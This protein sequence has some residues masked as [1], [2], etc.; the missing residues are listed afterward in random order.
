VAVVAVLANQAASA[1]TVPSAPASKEKKCTCQANTSADFYTNPT[2][3]RSSCIKNKNY[4]P[5]GIPVP[6]ICSFPTVTQALVAATVSLVSFTN[7]RAIL[8]GGTEAAPAFF[9]SESFPLSVVGGITLTTTD[10]PSLGGEGFH[11]DAYIILFNGATDHALAVK[12]NGAVSGFRLQNGGS[13][14]GS[15]LLCNGS[16]VSVRS[17][18]LDGTSATNQLATGLL[19]SNACDGTFANI[20][21]RNFVQQGI[22]VSSTSPTNS[23]FSQLDLHNNHIGLR[24]LGG[25]VV[26]KQTST[27]PGDVNRIRDNT[28]TLDTNGGPTDNMGYGIILGDRVNQQGVVHASIQDTAFQRNDVGVLVQQTDNDS[29]STHW[30]LFENQIVT[31]RAWGLWSYSSFLEPD[32]TGTTTGL[33]FNGNIIGNNGW[34]S[35]EAC[36]DALGGSS[37][38]ALE[39]FSQL[40]FSGPY[41]ASPELTA[42]CSSFGD[43]EAD[44]NSRHQ[45]VFN[46]SAP[47][48]QCRP[49]YDLSTIACSDPNANTITGYDRLG[50]EN[51]DRRVGVVVVDG[52]WVKAAYVRFLTIAFSLNADWSAVGTDSFAS[53]NDTV[54]TPAIT[55]CPLGP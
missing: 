3:D 52:A 14:T 25:N 5:T 2:V 53:N 33:I 9:A 24:V 1:Q 16:S 11:P 23:V 20:E 21:A 45:C 8:A 44:C 29:K 7:A 43:R 12:S 15:A 47:S 35:P 48:N 41:P 27:V 38:G 36:V 6:A 26:V 31:N 10:D 17:V 51:E 49:A 55:K 30:S 22:L 42:L 40:V 46:P 32:A 18:V 37:G 39:N 19:V 13:S 34:S 54:C 4:L 28:G 50:P